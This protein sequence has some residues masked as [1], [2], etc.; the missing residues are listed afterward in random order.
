[1]TIT[2][3]TTLVLAATFGL[4]SAGAASAQQ[5]RGTQGYLTDQR[6]LIVKDPFNLCWRTGYWTPAI[7]N[8]DC[9]VDLLPRDVCF[10]PAPKPA[11]APPPP[12]K[13]APAPAAKP[14]APK[15]LAVSSTG[16][17]DFDKAVLTPKAREQLDKEVVA[18]LGE[19]S[20]VRLI[21]IEG[22]TDRIG[23][24]EYNQKLSE[25]R[26][27]AVKAYLVSKGVDGAKIETIGMGK[28]LQ[29]KSCPDPSPKGEIRN[30][31]QLIECLAPNRRAVVT[32]S[33]TGR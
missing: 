3:R 8:C 14:P 22:H 23:T 12:A 11:A 29:I 24:Q 31:K 13:P 33:G 16:L 18:R 20:S 7:A 6:N 15:T 9:D 2:I 26:A 1:M 21:H 25:R 5:G 30:F 17:F 10:P 27:D 4:L 19:Y 32:V 28:T